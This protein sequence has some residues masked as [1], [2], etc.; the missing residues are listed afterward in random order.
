MNE[1][2]NATEF[3]ESLEK[4]EI[5]SQVFS[6]L[7]DPLF[8]KYLQLEASAEAERRLDFWLTQRFE[9]ELENIA[10]GFG[11]SATL[12]EILV[13]LVNYTEHSKVIYHRLVLVNSID[14]SLGTASRR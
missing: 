5:P 9:E 4:I 14:A 8:Q 11:L 13:G 3:V 2:Q 12:N 10:E 7:R 6:V 1:I